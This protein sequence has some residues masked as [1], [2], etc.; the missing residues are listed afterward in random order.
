MRLLQPGS[1]RGRDTLEGPLPA[2]SKSSRTVTTTHP[3]RPIV[4]DQETE[5]LRAIAEI[6][7]DPD[8][9]KALF[10]SV[11]TMEGHVHVMEGRLKSV[12]L[13]SGYHHRPQLVTWGVQQGWLD[14]ETP[15]LSATPQIVGIDPKSPNP[16]EEERSA[17]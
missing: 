17:G 16:V 15:R 3:S 10:V 13:K 6:G 1:M 5:V 8:A 14:T 11:H 9:A 4:T 12:R 2:P 7:Y